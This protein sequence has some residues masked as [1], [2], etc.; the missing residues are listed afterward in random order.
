MDPSPIY[1]W[2]DEHKDQCIEELRRVVRQPSIAAQDRGVKECARLLVEMMSGLGI[3]ARAIGAGGQP[4]VFGH[5]PS[6]SGNKTLVVYNHYDV[7]PPEPL[8]EWETDP[9][10]ATLVGDRIVARG[11][12]DSKGNLMAHLMAVRAYRE[13]CGDVP[14]G[15]KYVFDGQEEIGSPTIDRFVEENRSLLTADAGMSLD[16]GFDPSGRPRV[17]FGSSG[18][19]YIEV[20]TTGSAQGNLHSARARLVE[21]AAWKAVWIAASM[22]D[23]YENILVEGFEDAVT[24]P[25]PEERRMLGRSG[26]CTGR[27]ATSAGSRPATPGRGAR[28]CCPPGR[29]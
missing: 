25:S 14:V 24:G 4:V 23:R 21:S 19:L 29:S 5:L 17:Q 13:V 8:E 15:L 3:E 20:E 22:K 11:A 16:G 7:Q 27:P 26:C 12:T 9:F 10:A 18:L 6:R 1:S 28:Q 2:V